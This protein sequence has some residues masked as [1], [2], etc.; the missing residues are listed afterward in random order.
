MNSLIS[1]LW[2]FSG[3]FGEV[4]EAQHKKSLVHRAVKI[5]NKSAMNQQ[6]KHEL[7]KEIEI[8]RTLVNFAIVIG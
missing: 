5:I 1:N 8:L 4:I 2:F 6:E 3:S 7:M